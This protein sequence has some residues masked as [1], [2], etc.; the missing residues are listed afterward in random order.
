MTAHS[1]G[2][3]IPLLQGAN[4]FEDW[5]KLVEEELSFKGLAGFIDGTVP[6][7]GPEASAEE[8][9]DWDWRDTMAS[10]ILIAN[11]STDVFNAIR[12]QGWRRDM[13][14]VETYRKIKAECW[15]LPKEVYHE[16][17]MRFFR[18]KMSKFEKP[19]KYGRKMNT[20]W[21]RLLTV[22]PTLPEEVFVSVVLEGF[23]KSHPIW[24]DSWMM[25]LCQGRT[26][27]KGDVCRFL[28]LVNI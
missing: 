12:R 21:E 23:R 14:A 22:T 15:D 28:R 25:D 2:R 26:I 3:R 11:L 18:T 9:G 16:F 24:Y 6:K 8:A 5:E 19:E 13:T 10:F 20:M 7:P 4:D 27:S 1:D 17:L